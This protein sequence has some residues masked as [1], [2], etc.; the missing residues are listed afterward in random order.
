MREGWHRGRARY[1]RWALRAPQRA[2]HERVAEAQRALG[3]LVRAQPPADLHVTVFVVGFPSAAPVWDDDVGED[4]L[5]RQAAAVIGAG[6]PPLRLAVGASNAFLSC[7]FL[8]VADPHGDLARLRGLLV[9]AAREVRFAPYLPHVTVGIFP[10]TVPTAPLAA[11]IAPLRGLPPLSL[12]FDAVE[13]VDFDAAVPGAPLVT[14][15]RV[16]LR[17]DAGLA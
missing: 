14:R 16:A 10:A 4:A 3:G 6:L 1:A 2:L 13:L 11:A 12:E 15:R 5:D 17:G 7:A 9:G 8:E